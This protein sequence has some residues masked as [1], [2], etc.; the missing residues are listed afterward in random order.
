MT[1]GLPSSTIDKLWEETIELFH[2]KLGVTMCPT[3]DSA[4]IGHTILD[5]TPFRTLW[6]LLSKISP[7]S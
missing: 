6:G 3:Q 5:G 1:D 7:N 4:I 2:D